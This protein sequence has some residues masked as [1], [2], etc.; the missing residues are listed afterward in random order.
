MNNAL[1]GVDDLAEVAGLLEAVVVPDNDLPPVAAVGA[2]GG[3]QDPLFVDNGGGA[4]ELADALNG[5]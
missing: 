4:V 2:V 1:S 5:S 3:G